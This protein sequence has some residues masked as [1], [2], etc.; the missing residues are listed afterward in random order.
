MGEEADE[1][2]SDMLAM[3]LDEIPQSIERLL[4]AIDDRDASALRENAHQLKGSSRNMGLA[5]SGDVCLK[6]E[7][8]GKNNVLDGAL[9]WLKRLKGLCNQIGDEAGKNGI[10]RPG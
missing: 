4:A 9:H 7:E 8:M 3:Y 2:L 10:K 5:R 6:L 1:F